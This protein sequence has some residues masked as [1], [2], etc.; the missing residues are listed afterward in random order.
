MRLHH[1]SSSCTSHRV[2]FSR[3]AS[4]DLTPQHLE[5]VPHCPYQGPLG[6]AIVLPEETSA[7]N[8]YLLNEAIGLDNYTLVYFPLLE[9]TVQSRYHRDAIKVKGMETSLPASR[10][11]NSNVDQNPVLEQLGPLLDRF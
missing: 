8:W 1:L 2:L 10:R 4:Q 6:R 5:Y 7:H 11:A 3:S 9:K